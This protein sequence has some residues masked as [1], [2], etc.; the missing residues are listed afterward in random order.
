MQR[1]AGV[2][3]EMQIVVS[4]QPLILNHFPMLIHGGHNTKMWQLFGHIHTKPEDKRI[5]NEDRMSLL[6]PT[7]YDVG[8]DNNDFTPV[9]FER[10][11]EIIS[12]QIENGK[13]FR[14]LE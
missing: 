4:G 1:F 8:V 3:C 6:A 2:D 13:R 10:I 9:S 7:Q 14:A 11:K 5:I 12:W